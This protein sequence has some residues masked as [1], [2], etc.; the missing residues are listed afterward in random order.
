MELKQLQLKSVKKGMRV[1]MRID[2]NVPLKNGKVD[3]AQDFRLRAVVDDIE[4][5][6]KK[7]AVVILM[8]HLGR[9]SSKREAE[10]STQPVAKRLSVLL[11]RKVRFVPSVVGSNV[12]ELVVRAKGGDVFMLENLRFELGEEENSVEF[13]RQ[14]SALGELYVNNAFG[15]SHRA[16]A[17]VHAITQFLPSFAGSLLCNE[18]SSL[19]GSFSRP[20]AVILGGLKLE[21]K[22]P[23]IDRMADRTDAFFIGGGSG[24][25]CVSAQKGKRLR[26]AHALISKE[27]IDLAHDLLKRHG[28]KLY[29]P[30]DFIVKH[31]GSVK[32]SVCLAD[33]LKVSDR[34]YDIGPGTCVLFER[35]MKGVKSVF[36][37]GPMGA[38][39]QVFAQKGT[40]SLVR[41][42]D[43]LPRARKILGGGDTV[44]FLEKKKMLDSFSF[45]STGGGA[46]MALLSGESL[47]GLEVLQK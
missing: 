39:E 44:G 11:S 24:V 7:G 42:L 30:V 19:S 3:T 14:L 10:Y 22:I 23:L 27:E 21:T 43:S 35:L 40:L 45:V 5:L 20:A 9:P 33:D 16:H 6:C 41:S 1:L 32:P 25:A 18:V 8:T 46:M 15:V 34:I 17:S 47:P 31:K 4:R 38:V 29:F 13:A 36:W 37:N 28:S 26:L 2:A 12:A